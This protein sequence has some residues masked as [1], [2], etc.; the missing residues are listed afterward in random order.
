MGGAAMTPN[1]YLDECKTRH[2]S[3]TIKV[4]TYSYLPPITFQLTHLKARHI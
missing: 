3:L 1:S 4:M 2:S